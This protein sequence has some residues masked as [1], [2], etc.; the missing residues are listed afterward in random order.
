MKGVHVLFRY[1]NSSPNDKNVDLSKLKVFPDDNLNVVQ[2]MKF[3]FD[4][5]EN[6]LGRRENVGFQHL[7]LFP[8]CFPKG[9]FLNVVK[10]RDCL[11]TD[12]FIFVKL[13]F[14]FS[15]KHNL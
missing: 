2:R 4:R 1:I 11:N 14:L 5:V 8:H 7:L 6:I 10:T 13:K 12:V 15:D 3:V 9:F